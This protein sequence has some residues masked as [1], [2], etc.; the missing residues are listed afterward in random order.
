MGVWTFMD[1]ALTAVQALAVVIADG[2][3]SGAIPE[4]GRGGRD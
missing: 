1:A 2:F 3:L 4:R